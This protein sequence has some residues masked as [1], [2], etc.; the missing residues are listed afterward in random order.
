MT[1]A[2]IVVDLQ[3]DFCESGGAPANEGVAGGAGSLAVAG[4]AAGLTLVGEP[5][6]RS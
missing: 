6:L 1:S 5:A 3:N 4:G 2:V